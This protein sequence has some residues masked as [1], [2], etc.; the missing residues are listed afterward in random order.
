MYIIIWEYFVKPERL[1]EFEEIYS[2]NGAWAKLFQ[3]SRGFLKTE[4]LR[5]A[6]HLHCYITIDQWRS[7]SAYEQFLSEWKSEY[8]ALDARCEKLTEKEALLFKGE[9]VPR[10]T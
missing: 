6:E 4:L 3:K 7:S 9:S 8:L 1:A 10:E 5:D 2:Q